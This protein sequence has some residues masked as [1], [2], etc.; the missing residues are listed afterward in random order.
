MLRAVMAAALVLFALVAADPAFARHHQHQ[1]RHAPVCSNSDVMRPCQAR[2]SE[3][4]GRAAR[5][6]AL[7]PRGRHSASSARRPHGRASLGLGRTVS[8]LVAPLAAKV[9]EI[10][11]AC[12]SRLISGVR[13]TLIAGTR[14][15]S[16]HAAGK[17]ADVAGDPGCIYARL[18]GWPGGYSVDYAGVR[19]VHISWDPDGRREWGMRFRHG[20]GHRH[21]RRHH[22]RLASRR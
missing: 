14:T 12:G 10:Q 18:V 3:S 6:L 4:R 5:S 7:K 19:H 2:I 16:L 22:Q 15:I 1:A 21:A 8:G 17:A 9:A 11:A 20:G 13:H